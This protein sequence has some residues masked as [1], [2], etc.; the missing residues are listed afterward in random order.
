MKKHV[1]AALLALALAI[2]MLQGAAL[3]AK[4]GGDRVQAGQAGSRLTGVER[5]VYR[6]LREEVEKIAD[7][8][9]SSTAIRIPDLDALSWGLK[10]LGAEGKDQQTVVAKLDERLEQALDIDRVYTAQI[11]RAHV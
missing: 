8:S 5:E 6:I 4:P 9:R 3:A 7:G 10:E 1:V 11:G 2:G